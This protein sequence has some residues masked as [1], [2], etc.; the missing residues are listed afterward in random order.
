MEQKSTKNA[1]KIIQSVAEVGSE[2]VIK[3]IWNDVKIVVNFVK[4]LWN[5][6][7]MVKKLQKTC[8]IL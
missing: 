6:A 2:K 4:I 7:K 8:E 5:I 3:N 1:I